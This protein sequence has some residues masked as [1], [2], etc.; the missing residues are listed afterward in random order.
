MVRKHLPRAA[1]ESPLE[2]IVA[3]DSPRRIPAVLFRFRPAPPPAG[4]VWNWMSCRPN[5]TLDS[6]VYCPIRK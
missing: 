4:S 3:L 6:G 5:A 1:T 2:H